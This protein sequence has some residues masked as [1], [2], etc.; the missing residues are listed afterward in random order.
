MN[1]SVIT[2]GSIN[3]DLIAYC[4]R[5]PSQGETLLGD[6]F[7]I[8]VGGKG[9]NQA[10]RVSISGGNSIFIG[11]AG[12]D[13]FAEMIK[14][15]FCQCNVDTSFIKYEPTNTGIGHVRAINGNYD[16]V[17]V[18]GANELLSIRDVDD[19]L[20][21]FRRSSA[22]LLQLETPME[23][24]IHAAKVAK[25]NGLI[26]CLNAAPSK[27]LPSDFLGLL[28]ILVVNEIEAQM[29]SGVS[30][31]SITNGASGFSVG[32][33]NPSGRRESFPQ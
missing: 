16:T 4:N 5:S 12:Q 17:I 13:I 29:L 1:M 6:R 31:L 3:I 24:V 25:E 28:D 27:T 32:H 2:V 20:P 14:N 18:P 10:I 33:D 19:A 22:I 11:K 30:K 23:T 7:S 8:R 26:V 21:A 9:A 15:H